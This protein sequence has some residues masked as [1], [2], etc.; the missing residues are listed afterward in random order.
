MLCLKKMINNGINLKSHDIDKRDMNFNVP[1]YRYEYLI[2]L[3]YYF[4]KESGK[5]YLYIMKL[6]TGSTKF[7]RCKHN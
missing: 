7:D 5:Q 1:A 4:L 3:I 2:K 6:I